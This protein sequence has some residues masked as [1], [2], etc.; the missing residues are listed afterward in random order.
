M[1]AS[2]CKRDLTPRGGRE[3]SE[4]HAGYGNNIGFLCVVEVDSG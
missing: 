1:S 2:G 4:M 3:L